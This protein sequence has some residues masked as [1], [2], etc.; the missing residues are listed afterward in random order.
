MTPRA[1]V[2]VQVVSLGALG[3]ALLCGNVVIKRM[4]SASDERKIWAQ[5]L[6][7]DPKGGI[8]FG[9]IG[10]DNR[11]LVIHL[12][13]PASGNCRDAF[14]T[15]TV[16]QDFLVDAYARGFRSVECVADQDGKTVVL[17]DKIVPAPAAPAPPR[18]DG[19]RL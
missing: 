9:T 13:P 12:S 17:Q 3:F 19:A 18:K 8:I 2:A 7:G 1:R 10:L 4:I 15:L 14:F 16:R 11:T 6:N 5:K